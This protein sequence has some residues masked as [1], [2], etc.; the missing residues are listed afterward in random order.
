MYFFFHKFY[1]CLSLASSFDLMTIIGKAG[2][3]PKVNV[4]VD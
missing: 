2:D 3:S 1:P 4:V